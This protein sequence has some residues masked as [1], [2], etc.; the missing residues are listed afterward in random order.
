M[1]HGLEDSLELHE[2]NISPSES[3]GDVVLM[4][5]IS[6][7]VEKAKKIEQEYNE[8]LAKSS[9]QGDGDDDDGDKGYEDNPLKVEEDDYDFDEE[10]AKEAEKDDDNGSAD[11]DDG[12]GGASDLTWNMVGLSD[13]FLEIKQSLIRNQTKPYRKAKQYISFLNRRDGWYR[14][15]S[16]S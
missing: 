14:K 1:V 5:D 4:N 15:D 13:Q 10:M 7:F 6:R 9:P 2:L 16:S 11:D 3:Y 8:E 12:C